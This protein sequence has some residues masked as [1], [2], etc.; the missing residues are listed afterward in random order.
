MAS[1]NKTPHLQLNQWVLSDPFL[2]EDLNS[3]N[4]KIDTAMA[5]NPW[6]KLMDITIDVPTSCVEIDLTSFDILKFASLRIYFL[7][8]NSS[9]FI[10]LRW[11]KIAQ[12]YKKYDAFSG[13]QNSGST[14]YFTN[15]CLN[16]ELTGKTI[17]AHHLNEMY[18]QN[19]IFNPAQLTTID[20][21]HSSSGDSNFPIGRRFVLLGVRI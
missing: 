7:S 9:D 2:M 11:N 4:A 14:C 19:Q 20:L 10:Y 8:D 12:D 3:D 17:I 5:K 1:T 16:L 18:Q 15:G 21:M 6:E 13:W